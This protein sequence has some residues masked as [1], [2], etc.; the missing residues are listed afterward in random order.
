[1]VPDTK[2]RIPPPAPEENA[3]HVVAGYTDEDVI[4]DSEFRA[5]A[6]HITMSPSERD[7]IEANRIARDVLGVPVE[8]EDGRVV[9]SRLLDHAK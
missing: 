5:G 1:M 7:T 2:I 3:D 6:R 4:D 9:N 8:T